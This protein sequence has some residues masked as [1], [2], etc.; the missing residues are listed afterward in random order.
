MAHPPVF[1]ISFSMFSISPKKL[2]A[3][4]TLLPFHATL[5]AAIVI[6]ENL[7]VQTV[8][9]RDTPSALSETWAT[10]ITSEEFTPSTTHSEAILST[11]SITNSC[12]AAFLIQLETAPLKPNDLAP[13]WFTEDFHIGSL[14]IEISARLGVT[15]TDLKLRL[16]D[17]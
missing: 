6:I 3:P 7:E 13:S 10:R 14:P 4:L 11:R 9:T 5:D 12:Y 8:D 1:T 17:R 16:A 2:L 15:S